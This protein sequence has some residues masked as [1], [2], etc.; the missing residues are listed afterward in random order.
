MN[1]TQT[2]FDRT[3]TSNV[4]YIGMAASG[5]SATAEA[6]QIRAITYETD[7]KPLSIKYAGGSLDYTFAWSDRTSLTYS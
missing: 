7:S 5:T 2:L 4:E 3:S 1:G 6:W